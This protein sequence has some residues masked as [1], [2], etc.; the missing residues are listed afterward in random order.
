M[1]ACDFIL[2]IVGIVYEGL[3]KNALRKNQNILP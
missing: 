2:S 1:G 3:N